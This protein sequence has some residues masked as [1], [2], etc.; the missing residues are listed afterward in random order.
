MVRKLEKSN[1]EIIMMENGD[2]YL[3]RV[4][5]KSKKWNMINLNNINSVDI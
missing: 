2:V 5:P 4:D 3:K 1:N